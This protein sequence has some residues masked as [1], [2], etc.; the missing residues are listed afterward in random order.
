MVTIGGQQGHILV[1][2]VYS[3]LGIEITLRLDII[4]QA[5]ATKQTQHRRGVLMFLAVTYLATN[6]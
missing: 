6:T 5:S 3:S 2:V 1:T 4:Y